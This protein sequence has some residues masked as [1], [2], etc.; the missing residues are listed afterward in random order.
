VGGDLDTIGIAEARSALAWWLEAG[1]DCAIQ[2]EARDWLKPRPARTLDIDNVP[3][4]SPPTHQTLD[5]FH[6][7]LATSDHLPM[8]DRATRRVLPQG[9]EQAQVMLLVDAPEAANGAPISGQTWE[10]SRRM[11][12]AIKIP[13][14]QAYIASLSCF[15][16]PGARMT[17]SE[18]DACAEIARPHI[19]LAKPN[20][21]ILLGDGPSLALLGKRVIEARGHVHH[22]EG[23][24]TV[25]TFA[26][27]HLIK[28]PSNKRL[29]WQ[30]LLLLMEDE[31]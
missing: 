24:R 17:Q 31:S 4:P 2:E 29:A 11:L 22:V 27:A 18:R 7:W 9:K 15:H 21:L 16:A 19:A 5:Q 8:A 3:A 6:Q 13:E 10:L 14:S 26:P 23:V 30:D 1:V 20:R 28:Q 25:A 12:A